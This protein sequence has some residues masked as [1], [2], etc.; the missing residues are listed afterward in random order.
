MFAEALLQPFT[1]SRSSSL[2]R[3]I[4]VAYGAVKNIPDIQ[5]MKPRLEATSTLQLAYGEL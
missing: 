3:I 4:H 1:A 5:E 2:P